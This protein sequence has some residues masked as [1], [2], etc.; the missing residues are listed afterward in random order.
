MIDRFTSLFFAA[1]FI[2]SFQAKAQLSIS[3][4]VLDNNGMPLP[5]ASMVLLDSTNKKLVKSML[6]DS[7]GQFVFSDLMLGKYFLK[8]IHIGTETWQSDVINLNGDN[9]K[10]PYITLKEN[11]LKEVTVVAQKPFI[12]VKGD[13]LI[14]NVENSIVSAGSNALEVLSR[15]PGV[16][17]DQN[18]NISLKGRAGVNVMIDGRIVPVS[19]TD[20][21]NMLKNMPAAQLDKIEIIT[22]PSARY[23]AAG[24]AGIINIKTKKDQRM[25]FNGSAN[26]SFGHGFYPKVSTGFNINYR[27]KKFNFYGN[28]NYSYSE[29][30][31]HLVLTR[32]FY[33]SKAFESP[34]SKYDQD[35][36][37][38]FPYQNHNAGFGIDYAISGKTTTGINFSGYRGKLDKTSEVTSLETD[39]N[40][41]K[42]ASFQTKTGGQNKWLNFSSN[43]FLKHTFDSS[44]KELSIDGDYGRYQTNNTQKL[45]TN[46]F[47]GEGIST[48]PTYILDGD[49]NGTTQIRSLKADY[50]NPLKGNK[51]WEAGLKTSYV[52]ADNKPIFYD[53]SEAGNPVYDSGKSN[54]YIYNEN[55][56]AAYINASKEGEKWSFQLG[57]RA[58]QTNIKGIQKITNQILDTNYLK[59]FPSFAVQRKVNKNN[60]LG[61]TLSRRIQRPQYQQLNPFR[62]YMDPSTYAEGNPT[63][64][65]E[66]SY[67]LEL[68]HTFK[69]K[70]VTSFSYAYTTDVITH[71]ILP[72]PGRITVQTERNL[73]VNN[74]Y[75]LSA[76]YPFQFYKWWGNVTNI[77][78]FYS[79]YEGNLAN[80]DLNNGLPTYSINSTNRFTISQTTS[81]ELGINYNQTWNYKDIFA[82]ISQSVYTL[83]LF[84]EE[85][86]DEQILENNELNVDQ[87]S[88]I[89]K[90][91]QPLFKDLKDLY[92]RNTQ[93]S[94]DSNDYWIGQYCAQLESA[95]LTNKHR[96]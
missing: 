72:I 31:N 17:V 70:F 16:I 8:G 3:G 38:K 87:V 48:L 83:Y 79:K 30:F 75:G 15:S 52:T 53:R 34:F 14:V 71:V 60:D 58:E 9:I 90:P 35:H 64:S 74:Y 6:T 86:T 2:I 20:L 18:D 23:D 63:L 94:I 57:L 89:T 41:I 93:L 69:Q 77:N 40:N 96:S 22:N 61:L 81:A 55:I 51:R 47:N 45:I 42:I 67:S 21:A 92:D 78:A 24:N 33:T 25:G 7:L 73:A 49:I 10:L 88:I 12:E 29:G 26:A 56:N 1:F 46:Y 76:S 43:A 39:P 4:K 54:H 66:T 36:Y 95:R 91:Y 84:G 37:A 19:G 68:Q 85:P 44:G 80:T 11:A 28:Y 59:L 82:T 62:Y 13:R 32:R 50:V 27:N 5:G 65:P